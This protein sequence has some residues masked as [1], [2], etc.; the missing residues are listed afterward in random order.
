MG[1]YNEL[2]QILIDITRMEVYTMKCPNCSNGN[3]ILKDQVTYEYSYEIGNNGKV[4][5]QDDD[6]YTSYLFV[7]RE[8][9]DFKQ[10]VVCNKCHQIFDHIIE[11]AHDQDMIILKKAIHSNGPISKDLFV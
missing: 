1:I 2:L 4:K 3:L 10:S 8:Q 7:N 5:W 11:R 9:K 6:G